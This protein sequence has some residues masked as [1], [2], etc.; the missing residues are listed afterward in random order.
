MTLLAHSDVIHR[1]F[2]CG[3]C[4]LTYDYGA[5]GFNCPIYHRFRLETY[6][7]GGLMWLTRGCLID[8]DLEWGP[9]LSHI[10]FSCTMC[11]NCA[12]QC[13]FDFK[14]HLLDIFRSVREEAVETQRPLP[15]KVAQFLENVYLYGNPYREAKDVRSDWVEELGVR[16]FSKGDEFLYYV[17]CVGS[18]DSRARKA[19]KALAT[20]LLEAGVSFGILGSQEQCDGNEVKHLGESGLFEVL[21]DGNVRVFRDLGVKKIVTLSPHSYNAFKKDY[22]QEFE[23]CHY[24][25]LLRDLIEQGRLKP[26][27]Q[28]Q[29]TVTYHDPCFL[30]RHN[31][32]YDAPREVLRA[33]PGIDLVEMARYGKNAFCCGGGGG[34]FY[35]GISAS[36]K[37]RASIARVREAAATGA[38]VL[39]VACPICLT[40]LEDAL[41]SE[42]LDE[43]LVVKDISEIAAE[44]VKG[45]RAVVDPLRRSKGG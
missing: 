23:V 35:T 10:L 5:E 1:C 28:P 8:H 40:M 31:E 34:N 45:H 30:G 2:R 44:S 3:F 25:Q 7:P 33:L 20:L 39:A 32:E 37:E 9:H 27:Q 41:K 43:S 19:A 38:S 11:G 29:I 24:T 22:P 4:K 12:E 16:R 26:G 14:T 17:G 6:S 42:W 21:R 13:R 15:P 36:G 18:Y